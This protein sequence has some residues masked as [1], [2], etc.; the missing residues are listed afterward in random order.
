[1]EQGVWKAGSPVPVQLTPWL[2]AGV[3]QERLWAEGRS[4]AS[5]SC[6]ARYRRPAAPAG[7]PE[8]NSNPSSHWGTVNGAARSHASQG[9]G[10]GGAR[11]EWRGLDLACCCR[12]L[13]LLLDLVFFLVFFFETAG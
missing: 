4:C 9:L 2:P 5:H 13:L 1:M 10:V 8:R 6:T 11:R 3:H 12:R 7:T